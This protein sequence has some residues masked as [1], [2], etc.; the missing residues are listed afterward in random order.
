MEDVKQPQNNNE[1]IKADITIDNSIN[2]KLDQMMG[3]FSKLESRINQIDSNLEK[4]FINKTEFNT[5]PKE[6]PTQEFELG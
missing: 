1:Q 3:Y 4:T 2:D 5:E 6:E